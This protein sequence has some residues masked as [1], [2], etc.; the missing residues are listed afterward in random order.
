MP[1]VLMHSNMQLINVEGRLINRRKMNQSFHRR[2]MQGTEL[3]LQKLDKHF[4]IVSQTEARALK[5]EV[6]VL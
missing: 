3:Y 2:A 4:K 5:G 6:L 1:S